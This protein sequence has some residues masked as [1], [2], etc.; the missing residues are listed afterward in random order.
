[1][2]PC[3]ITDAN[4]CL[5]PENHKSK[6]LPKRNISQHFDTFFRASAFSG[7]TALAFPENGVFSPFSHF[8]AL[9]LRR[10]SKSNRFLRKNKLSVFFTIRKA[11]HLGRI[12]FI[13]TPI[14]NLL[15]T[16]H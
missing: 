6:S 2:P 10:N 16:W 8:I 12:Y 15:S 4:I 7:K 9:F 11:V 13:V 5:F 1:M 14:F 3:K